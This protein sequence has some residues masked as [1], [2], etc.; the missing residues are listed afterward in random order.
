MQ[1]IR[2]RLLLKAHIEC[3]ALF[4]VGLDSKSTIADLSLSLRRETGLVVAPASKALD[5]KL[6]DLTNY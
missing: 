1:A 5:Y 3:L 2:W 4:Y 6:G